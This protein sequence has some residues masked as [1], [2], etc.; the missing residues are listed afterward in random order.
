MIIINLLEKM[1]SMY[2]YTEKNSTD[3]SKFLLK[4]V[5]F[6]KKK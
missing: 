4:G 2:S 3:L 1:L 6:S 5:G